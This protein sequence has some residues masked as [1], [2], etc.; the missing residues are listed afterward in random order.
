MVAHRTYVSAG[1]N[2]PVFGV[3]G[4]DCYDIWLGH[5]KPK[6]STTQQLAEVQPIRTK[7][8]ARRIASRD[9]IGSQSERVTQ[10][11]R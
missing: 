7:A 6:C 1:F 10:S 2:I 9:D 5:R 8:S 4:S 3:Y 11:S